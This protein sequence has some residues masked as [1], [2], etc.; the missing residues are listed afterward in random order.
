MKAVNLIPVEARR[1]G[2]RSGGS[3]YVLLGAMTALV[4]VA[5]VWVLLNNKVS[6]GNA[7]VE[8][9][10][11]ETAA[12]QQEAI[13][14]APFRSFAAMRETRVATVRS[15]AQSR[16]EWGPVMR[17]LALVLPRDVWLSS[18]V[19]TVAPGVNVGSEGGSDS[20]S[21]R[22]ALAVP[23]VELSGCASSQAQV[24]RTLTRLRLIDGVT[25]VSLGSTEKNES[26]STQTNVSDAGTSTGA[27]A[28]TGDCRRTAKIPKFSIVVFYEP[29]A[30]AT[31][32][33][34][35]ATGATPSTPT[36]GTPPAPPAG[37]STTPPAP[38][39]TAPAGGGGATR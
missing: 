38:G 30:G 19:G 22:Q 31:G 23:A 17:K 24:A 8:Q 35:G 32:G 20:S 4:L 3:V 10:R 25:R 33:R 29:E 26:S 39:A 11:V 27:A 15:L 12:A 2:E 34:P 7:R 37:S 18:M 1:G 36:S 28:G 14:L 13:A 9:L 16:F 5:A 6:E 21:L